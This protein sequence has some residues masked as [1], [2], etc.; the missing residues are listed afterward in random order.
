MPTTIP[1]PIL[2]TSLTQL[3]A[4]D[5][6]VILQRLYDRDQALLNG[7]L[8][9]MTIRADLFVQFERVDVV[10]ARIR[11]L[12]A[13]IN[14]IISSFYLDIDGNGVVPDNYDFFMKLIQDLKSNINSI[15]AVVGGIVN[16]LNI[17][18]LV[19]PLGER[20]AQLEDLDILIKEKL[21][22]IYGKWDIN[23]NDD[24]LS[25]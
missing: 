19:G 2:Y 12:N 20:L 11:S 25:L 9:L 1:D 14:A 8:A 3:Q 18:A 6:N 10:E 23:P 16:F 22:Y 5:E 4:E 17:Q 15:N 24:I 7:L 21:N 13:V